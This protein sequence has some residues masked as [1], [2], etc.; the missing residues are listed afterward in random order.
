MKYIYFSIPNVA[1]STIPDDPS[2]ILKNALRYRDTKNTLNSYS[3]KV[4][5]KPKL[6]L[7][8]KVDGLATDLG[9][10]AGLG[11]TMLGAKLNQYNPTKNVGLKI[12]TH[13]IDTLLDTNKSRMY[14]Y[15]IPIAGAVGT[16]LLAKKGID[17]INNNEN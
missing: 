13:G 6:N 9:S 17:S 4:F 15:G 10:G 3:Q 1:A 7:L 5:G 14:G 16:G 12:K 11:L 2:F 8:E